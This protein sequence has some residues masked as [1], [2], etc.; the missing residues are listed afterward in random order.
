MFHFSRKSLE[1]DIRGNSP[2]LAIIAAGAFFASYLIWLSTDVT[3]PIQIVSCVYFFAL[4]PYLFYRAFPIPHLT[5]I[6]RGL[7][8]L[9]LM[10]FFIFPIQYLLYTV[11]KLPVYS[12]FFING[13]MCLLALIVILVEGW[14]TRWRWATTNS[15]ISL[16]RWVDYWPLLLGLCAYFLLHYIFYRQYHYIP[17]WDS[18]GKLA[19]IEGVV[20]SGEIGLTYRGFFTGATAFL[21]IFTK[22]T[23]Y[24]LFTGFYIFLQSSLIFCL[25]SLSRLYKIKSE[26][27]ILVILV[28]ALAVPVINMEIDT[29][30]PQNMIVIFLPIY[31]YFLYRALH[32]H[33]FIYW[34]AASLIA[35]GGLN[36]HEFF[37][38]IFLLH[39]FW[40]IIGSIHFFLHKAKDWKDHT[41]IGLVLLLLFTNLGTIFSQFTFFAFAK[42]MLAAII[43][44]IKSAEWRWWFLDSYNTDGLALDIGWKGLTGAA[45][46]YGYYMGPVI[47]LVILSLLTLF[48][49]RPI[50]TFKDTA[51]QICGLFL[52]VFLFFAEYLPRI[53]FYYL[54]ERFWILITLAG[55][56]LLVPLLAKI[57]GGEKISLW[58]KALVGVWIVTSIIGIGGSFY[59]SRTKAALTSP[60]EYNAAMWIKANTVQNA[61]FFSQAANGPMVNYFAKRSLVVPVESYFLNEEL[62]KEKTVIQIVLPHPDEIN[63]QMADEQK[64][65]QQA[66]DVLESNKFENPT[67]FIGAFNASTA[68]IQQLKDQL[69]QIQAAH[70]VKPTIKNSEVKKIKQPLYI[71]YSFHKFNSLYSQREWWQKA[72]FYGA[73]LDKFDKAYPLVYNKNGVMIWEVR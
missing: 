16:S 41:I 33:K 57:D 27:L 21:S 18:Y 28:A 8:Y 51:I 1:I 69:Q 52:L 32:D 48:I 11:F 50:K 26:W 9:V 73:A 58:R 71:L 43:I 46:Y 31:T 22:L 14:K 63:R 19:E 15:P 7:L 23:P 59:I 37:V 60:A 40:I 24:Q 62:D 39:I 5:V 42:S 65:I 25:Y 3:W 45:Q 56:P 13:T 35:L 70:T 54:P 36:Y 49:T 2:L 20:R 6:E 29:V 72:N 53:G 66:F 61:V 44:R 4:L 55:L 64:A 68:H 67:A 12:D 38:F 47:L 10:F 30:R 34:A 17:E